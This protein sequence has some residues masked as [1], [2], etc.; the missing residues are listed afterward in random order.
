MGEDSKAEDRVGMRMCKVIGCRSMDID[1]E[2]SY[3]VVATASNVAAPLE[4]APAAV[5]VW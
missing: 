2:H 1:V 5:K 4:L 3:G